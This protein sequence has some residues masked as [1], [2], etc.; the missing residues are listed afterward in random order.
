MEE[1]QQEEN[2]PVLFRQNAN[3][4]LGLLP[5][6]GYGRLTDWGNKAGEIKRFAP[7]AAQSTNQCFTFW[8]NVESL[9]GFGQKSRDGRILTFKWTNE[10]TAPRSNTGGT[11]SLN[12]PTPQEPLCELY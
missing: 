9:R 8:P 4:S 1:Q 11:S 7:S 6:I 12:P 5:R 10:M 3:S 2:S